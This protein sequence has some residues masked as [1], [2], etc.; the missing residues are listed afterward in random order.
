MLRLTRWILLGGGLILWTSTFPS[1]PGSADEPSAIDSPRAATFA[2][3]MSSALSNAAFTA[4]PLSRN[5]RRGPDLPLPF[6]HESSV[7]GDLARGRKLD[8]TPQQRL[9][10]GVLSRPDV[11]TEYIVDDDSLAVLV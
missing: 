7:D 5:L 3:A 11:V 4:I 2:A 8:T 10:G 9:E 1:T 6:A